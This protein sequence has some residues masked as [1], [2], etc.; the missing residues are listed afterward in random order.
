M[1]VRVVG[2][3]HLLDMFPGGTFDGTEIIAEKEAH[4]CAPISAC[5]SHVEITVGHCDAVR[6]I[7]L[8]KCRLHWIDRNHL[9][10]HINKDRW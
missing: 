3:F 10:V 4:G 5:K 8:G 1:R 9:S 6:N 7:H 2:F